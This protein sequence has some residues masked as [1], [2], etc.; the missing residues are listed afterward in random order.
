MFQQLRQT[1][2][3]EITRDSKKIKEELDKTKAPII[4]KMN[5]EPQFAIIPLDQLK[6]LA[7]RVEESYID[8]LLEL[9]DIANKLSIDKATDLSINHD[10]Y[11]YGDK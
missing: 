4:V 11:I 9:A 2:I 3:R 7:T 1:T 6:N 8:N 10:T 5:S